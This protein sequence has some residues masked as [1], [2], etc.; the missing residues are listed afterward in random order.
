[1]CS[2]YTSP[3][4]LLPS[5][6]VLKVT[7]YSTKLSKILLHYV[8][9]SVYSSVIAKPGS[10]FWFLCTICLLVVQGSRSG[11]VQGARCLRGER[12]QA[13]RLCFVGTAGLSEATSVPRW[14]NM[15]NTLTFFWQRG[16]ESGWL[17]MWCFSSSLSSA[18]ARSPLQIPP[19]FDWKYPI[20]EA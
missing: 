20:L 5:P 9:L 7:G 18:A 11:A 17:Q 2:L 10:W 8:L 14:H 19:K 3:V 12:W 1:M 13:A 16:R 6:L 15:R 4:N